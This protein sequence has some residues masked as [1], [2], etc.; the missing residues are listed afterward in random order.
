MKMNHITSL[1]YDKI[2]LKTLDAFKSLFLGISKMCFNPEFY[3][4]RSH[5]G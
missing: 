2:D 4:M 3:L 1:F 5:M